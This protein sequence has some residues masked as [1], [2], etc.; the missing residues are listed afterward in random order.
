LTVVQI[1]TTSFHPIGPAV[2]TA[3]TLTTTAAGT[4]LA[5]TPADLFEFG[6]EVAWHEP[7]FKYCYDA[8]IGT[9]GGEKA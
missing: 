4:E 8:L 2:A 3:A 1:T 5:E 9:E 7:H 6:I